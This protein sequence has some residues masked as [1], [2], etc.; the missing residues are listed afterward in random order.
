MKILAVS[1]VHGNPFPLRE[2][3]KDDYEMAVFLG[4]AVD[5]GP[6]PAETLDIIKENF[7]IQ[8]MGNHDY[9]VAYGVDCRCGEENHDLSVYTRENITL[10]LISKEDIEFI[11]SFRESASLDAGEKQFLLYHGA[12]WNP[13]YGYIFPWVSDT[14]SSRNILGND[15]GDFFLIGH[16]HY[17]FIVTKGGKTFI[18]PGSIGQ[19]RDLIGS[20]SYLI[21]DTEKNVYQFRRIR[22][23]RE[24]IHRKLEEVIGDEK[25]LSKAKSMF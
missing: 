14:L 1:D 9:A 18:N 7:D 23:E 4:D 20:S 16:S 19:P 8:I 24:A 10:K 21:I 15:D 3:L 5:Y 22:Y 13:L 6:Y 12:P 11:K 2:A 25:M 17:Q